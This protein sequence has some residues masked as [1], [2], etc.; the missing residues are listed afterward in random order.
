M[1]PWIATVE[2]YGNTSCVNIQLGNVMNLAGGTKGEAR[3]VRGIKL[4]AS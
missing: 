4:V 2:K 3:K 1:Q